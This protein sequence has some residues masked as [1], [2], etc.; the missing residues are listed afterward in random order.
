[1]EIIRD[2]RLGEF[3]V[4]VGINLLRGP[5]CPKRL[6]CRMDADKEGFLRRKA[7]DSDNGSCICKPRARHSVCRPNHQTMWNA[8]DETQGRCTKQIAYNEKHGNAEDY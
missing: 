6:C 8:M 3:D 4:L 7:A 2:L 5:T 1:M